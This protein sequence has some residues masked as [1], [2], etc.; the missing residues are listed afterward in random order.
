MGRGRGPPFDG[1]HSCG[2]R[3]AAASTFLSIA[4]IAR[5]GRPRIAIQDCG[6]RGSLRRVGELPASSHKE[7]D[8]N[9]DADPNHAQYLSVV[10]QVYPDEK[11]DQNPQRR[12][13]EGE[14]ELLL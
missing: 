7:R 14:G 12:D 11:A 3:A 2:P 1:E 6:S 13:Q 10:A 9:T 4:H 5:P 8:E